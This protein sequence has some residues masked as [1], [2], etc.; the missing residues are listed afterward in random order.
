L[1]KRE[2]EIVKMIINI[3]T[4]GQVFGVMYIVAGGSAPVLADRNAAMLDRAA[5]VDS[6]KI[7]DVVDR[8]LASRSIRRSVSA[9]ED[10][11]TA[12]LTS[13]DMVN[14]MLAIEAAF[15]LTISGAD[16]IPANFRSIGAIVRLLSKLNGHS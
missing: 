5:S 15:D 10:L 12:G 8:F 3:D 1:W 2:K 9:E 7:I 14:L 4:I 6:D 11:Q 16:L 13:L